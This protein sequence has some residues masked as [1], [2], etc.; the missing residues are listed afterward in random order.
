MSGQINLYNPALRK[1]KAYFP[2]RVFM[3]ALATSA[4]ILFGWTGFIVYQTHKL[5]LRTLDAQTQLSQAKEDLAK[6]TA[7]KIPRAKNQRL[8]A[9]V[10]DFEVRVVSLLKVSAELKKGDFGNAS[11]YSG[12]LRAF[13]KQRVEGIWLTG[14]TIADHGNDIGLQGQALQAL[15]LPQYL[16]RLSNEEVLRGK[17]F[18]S[19]EMQRRAAPVATGSA[20]PVP[21]APTIVANA[22]A[23]ANGLAVDSVLANAKEIANAINNPAALSG[24]LAKLGGAGSGTGS[25]KANPAPAL[26]PPVSGASPA[27]VVDTSRLPIEFNLQARTVQMG[28]DGKEI[29]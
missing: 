18:D 5:E 6:V 26:V 22:V 10:K 23:P 8:E 3:L 1:K 11:G 14:V 9:Q 28:A 19:L 20:G 7:E 12:Y 4:L 2:A 17:A 24:L 13:A 25:A 16:Q 27:P 21:P 15:L 29:K